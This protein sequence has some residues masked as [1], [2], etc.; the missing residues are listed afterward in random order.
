MKQVTIRYNGQNYKAMVN[1]D[2]NKVVHVRRQNV[3]GIW[4]RVEPVEFAVGTVLGDKLV[5]EALRG[6]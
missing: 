3:I 6:D 4:V 5:E 1:T 2:I